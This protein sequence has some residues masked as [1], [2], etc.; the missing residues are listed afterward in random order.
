MNITGDLSSSGV[1]A[2][3]SNG[4]VGGNLTVGGLINGIDITSLSSDNDVHLK[5]SS[6]AGL[7]INIASGDYRIGGNVTQ[8]A[9]ASNLDVT[10]ETTNYVYFTSTGV[11]ITEGEFPTNISYIPVATVETAGGAITA[12]TDRRVFNS[13]DTERTVTRTFRPEFE[14]A[15]YLGDGSSNVGQLKVSH[16]GGNLMNYYM[17]TS[18]RSSLNDYDVL[19][20][21]TLPP[22]FVRWGSTPLAVSYKS[23]SA[24]A[25]NNKLDIS[26]TDSAD[27]SVTL[28]GTPTG[29]ASTG[30]TTTTHTY[31]GTPTWTAGSGSL[32]RLRMYAKDNEEMHLGTVKLTYVELLSE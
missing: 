12:V 8:Y 14:G 5:V 1:L 32:V 11:V 21:F 9:G 17:W 30:W 13:D 20:R 2:V 23:S 16:S 26:L 29:L 31:S 19:L 10:D 18:S 25:A 15:S 3:E 22:D 6:G 7:K 28:S 27:N 24:N 4:T